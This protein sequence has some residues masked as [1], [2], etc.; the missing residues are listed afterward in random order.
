MKTVTASET[1]LSSSSL[2]TLISA[3]ILQMMQYSSIGQN[4]TKLLD[5][6]SQH[7]DTVVVYSGNCSSSQS[8]EELGAYDGIT[9]H[10]S[11]PPRPR[12]LRLEYT[13]HCYTCKHI[14]NTSNTT[15]NSV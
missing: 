9:I 13:T 3:T 15:C 6:K 4:K 11:L 5:T 12:L 14:Q 1:K 8:N 2:V 10:A 7:L